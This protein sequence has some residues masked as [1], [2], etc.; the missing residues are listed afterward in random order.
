MFSTLSGKIIFFLKDI[1]VNII[2]PAMI[3]S[4]ISEVNCIDVKKS[5]YNFPFFSKKLFSSTLARSSLIL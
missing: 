1:I 3:G 4:T 5:E 2:P